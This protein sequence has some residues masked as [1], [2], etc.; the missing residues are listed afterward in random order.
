M[1]P[2]ESAPADLVLHAPRV[3][4]FASPSRIA[5]RYG[6]DAAMVEELLLDFEANGWVRHSSFAGTSG[7]S[8]TDAGRN[9]NE[10]QM[11]TELDR[12]EARDTVASVHA[13]FIPLNREF[14]HICTD[15]QI[16]PTPS[17]P[18]S[19]NDHSD[20]AWDEGVLRA[21][22]QVEGA[23][24]NLCHRLAARLRRFDGYA[25]RFS[26]ALAKVQSGLPRWVD[27][28]DVDSCH[29]VWIQFHEDLLATLGIPRG[30]DA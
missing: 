18:M 4:G 29:T 9:E 1:A 2:W 12:A 30:S 3:L 10:R 25:E 27:A 22:S 14:G 7:W 28:P 17:E 20:V 13:K 6:L 19:F 26:H 8:V 24:G 21:L 15:W 11:A 16:R 5:A 23:F